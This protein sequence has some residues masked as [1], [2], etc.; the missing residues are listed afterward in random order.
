MLDGNRNLAL[1]MIT[2]SEGI[3]F[4]DK[5]ILTITD[6]EAPTT[7]NF[8]LDSSSISE[9]DAEELTVSIKLSNPATMQGKITIS[10]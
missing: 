10:L 4:G 9:S 7:A 6:D 1:Q 5:Q 3:E 2:G 8:A